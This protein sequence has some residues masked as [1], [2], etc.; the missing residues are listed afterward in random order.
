LEIIK[1]HSNI[2][3]V[4]LTDEE[5]LS[6]LSGRLPPPELSDISQVRIKSNNLTSENYAK[7]I[8]TYKPKLII[9]WNGRLESI[10]NFKASLS[11]YR[12]LTSLSK[13]KNIYIRISK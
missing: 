5:I 11:N 4:V 10:K 2:N 13:S 12:L 9:P 7:I 3:D 8:N 1:K 6:G